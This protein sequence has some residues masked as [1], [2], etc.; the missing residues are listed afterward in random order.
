MDKERAGR[1]AKEAMF[2]VAD[3]LARNPRVPSLDGWRAL[4]IALVIG[5]HV[6]LMSAFSGSP[7]A[8]IFSFGEYGV[9]V[10]FV[11][12]GFLITYLLLIEKQKVGT[13]SI[14]DFYIRRAYRILP[15]YFAF[16][17]TVFVITLITAFKISGQHW[18]QLLTFTANYKIEEAV[19]GPVAHIWSLSVEEQ[20]YL[21]WPSLLLLTLSRRKPVFWTVIGIGFFIALPPVARLAGYVGIGGMFTGYFSFFTRCDGIALG[22]LAAALCVFKGGWVERN[23]ARYFGILLFV[24]L[25]AIAAVVISFKEHLLGPVMLPF[26]RTLFGIG[27]A[28][29]IVA[30]IQFHDRPMFAWL[31]WRPVVFVGMLSYSLYIWQQLFT[32][33]ADVYGLETVPWYLT[34]ELFLIPLF[35]VSYGMHL[36]VER[37]FLSLKNRLFKKVGNKQRFSDGVA[38]SG[39]A[40]DGTAPAYD[41]R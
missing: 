8:T 1:E 4:S 40:T 38:L 18:A 36:A 19:P 26:G 22:A 6:Q 32:T 14:K 25:T 5:S 33:R 35:A 28:I 23:I 11:L 17:G 16:M 31:N 41:R 12:S 29:I 10:F 2:D 39:A 34:P 24:S 20:F 3:F 15:I 9:D 37:P 13:I 27:T 21:A 30:S 7:D